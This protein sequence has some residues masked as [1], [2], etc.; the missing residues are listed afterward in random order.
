MKISFPPA[1][2]LGMEG[3]R[4]VLE[5]RSEY[6]FEN[7]PFVS[8]I[9]NFFPAGVKALRLDKVK[10][11]SASL[12]KEIGSVVYSFDLKQKDIQESLRN[13]IGKK[14][15]DLSAAFEFAKKALYEEA[16]PDLSKVSF[17]DKKGR[18]SLEFLFSPGKAV[19]I[20]SIIQKIFDV[21]YPNFI[22]SR[23]K[24]NFKSEKTLK[25]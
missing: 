23:E 8:R 9:N 24:I 16:V 20:R 11:A 2:G 3:K 13:R 4:E 1:L 7:D 22:A 10:P 12:S 15:E 6:L 19:R 21:E 17:D 18:V 14:A 25:A 5:F